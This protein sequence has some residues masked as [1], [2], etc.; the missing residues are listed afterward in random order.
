[1]LIFSGILL[2]VFFLIF[3][4][5]VDGPVHL[6]WLLICVCLGIAFFTEEN[7]IL[8]LNIMEILTLA[9]TILTAYIGQMLINRFRRKKQTGG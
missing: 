2:G 4:W 5:A 3:L 6:V 8:G 9:A 7:G 1:M